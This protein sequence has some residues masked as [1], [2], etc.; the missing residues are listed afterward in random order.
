MGH[1]IN[2]NGFRVGISKDWVSRWYLDKRLFAKSLLEDYK[3]REL[4]NKKLENAGVRSIEIERSLNQISITAK[5]SKPG[6]VIGKGGSE[7]EMLKEELKKITKVKTSLSVEEVKNVETDAQLVADYI[8]RQLKRRVPYR[9]VMV[10]A[11]NSAIE[12]GA[13]GIKIKLSG[14]LSGPMSIARSE[15]LKQGPVPSQTIRADI[16]FAKTDCLMPYGKIGI[17]VWIYKGIK[18]I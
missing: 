18:E 6:V 10:T 17:K 3:I 9:R 14:L 15:T 8:S 7:V 2:P 16:D 4:L 11:I 5:V 13:K 12:K 1:K